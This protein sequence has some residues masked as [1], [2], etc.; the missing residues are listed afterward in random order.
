LKG[1]KVQIDEE[2]AHLLYD[3]NWYIQ[4]ARKTCYVVVSY[5]NK[6]LR[7]HREIMNT[8]SGLETDHIDGNGLNNTKKNL[9]ICTKAQNRQNRSIAK[10]NHSG[11]IGVSWHKAT[12][13]W[14]AR[15]GK[16][17]EHLGWFDDPRSAYEAYIKRAKERYGVFA[18]NRGIKGE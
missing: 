15:I 9:R 11:F 2:D 17:K 6:T 10:S 18:T 5:K 4:I 8:P 1:F 16:E 3:H 12:G 14:Q 13:R 7:L